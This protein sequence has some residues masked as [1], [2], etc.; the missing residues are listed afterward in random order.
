MS[1]LGAVRAN[2]WASYPATTPWRTRGWWVGGLHVKSRNLYGQPLGPRTLQP[3]PGGPEVGGLG[4][5]M[6]SL[7]A[8]FG[9]ST[10]QPYPGGPEVGWLG[11]VTL[12]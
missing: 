6:K 12:V 7:G 2:T 9:P 8:T 3:H 5:C 11:A 10:L 4:G 1:S